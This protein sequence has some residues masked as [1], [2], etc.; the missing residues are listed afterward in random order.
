MCMELLTS[1]GWSPVY[2]I[3]SVLLQIRLALCNLEPVP[4]RLMFNGR[5]ISGVDYGIAEAVSAYTRVSELH[6]WKVPKDIKQT[7]GAWQ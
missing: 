2:T 5:P 3:E 1:T 4:A 7:G 6:G